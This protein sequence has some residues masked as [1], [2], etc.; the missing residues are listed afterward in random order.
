MCEK[1]N[2]LFLVTGIFIPG[3]T[4]TQVEEVKDE[5]VDTPEPTETPS[6]MLLGVGCGGGDE[7]DMNQ[8]WE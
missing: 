5:I 8:T 3:C 1:R 7:V 2:L 6:P 4:E